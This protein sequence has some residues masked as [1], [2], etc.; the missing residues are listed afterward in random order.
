MTWLIPNTIGSRTGH[1][2]M[3]LGVFMNVSRAE[4]GRAGASFGHILTLPI[5]FMATSLILLTGCATAVRGTEEAVMINSFPQ[6]AKLTIHVEEGPNTGSK[7]TC[8]ATPCT[9]NLSRRTKARVTASIADYPSI[10]FLLVSHRMTSNV[11][12]PSGVIVAGMPDGPHVIAGSPSA[13]KALPPGG[14]SI[15]GGVFSYGIGIVVDQA[16]GANRSIS[17]NPVTIIFDPALS[18]LAENEEDK[19]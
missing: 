1:I 10:T 6:G 14:A 13:L 18:P 5:L 17:P 3:Y 11:A 7:F 19:S 16:S 2:Y 15:T 12:T 8:S 4:F 9:L